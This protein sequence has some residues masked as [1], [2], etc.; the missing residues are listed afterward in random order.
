MKMIG[1]LSTAPIRSS[2]TTSASLERASRSAMRGPART[3]LLERRRMY[4]LN[5]RLTTDSRSW[6]GFISVRRVMGP[7]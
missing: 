6:L 2:V 5:C 7:Q 4:P 1:S 3:T